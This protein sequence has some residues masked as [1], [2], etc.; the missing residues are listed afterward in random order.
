MKV[1]IFNESLAPLGGVE[2][3]T[4]YVAQ[5]LA[6]RG[7]EVTVI[8]LHDGELHADFSAVCRNVVQVPTF[9]ISRARG[10]RQLFQVLPTVRT[11]ARCRSDVICV[12][13]SGEI[14]CA[15]LAGRVA[16]APVVCYFHGFRPGGCG[17]RK[18][19]YVSK[20]ITVSKFIR[21]QWV[22]GG[23]EADWIEVVH[24]GVDQADY[25]I[26]GLD[27][28]RTA[29]R[30]L[31]LPEDGFLALYYG[32][33]DPLKGIGVLLDAWRLLG[34]DPTMNRLLV[35]GSPSGDAEGEAYGEEIRAGAPP[36]CHWLPSRQDV[37][38]PLH[39]ADVVVVPSIVEEAFSR[40]VIEGM[41]TG[42]PVVAA[43]IGGIPEILEERF[44]RLLFEAGDAVA[45]AEVVRSVMHWR[46]NEPE[47]ADA[48]SAHI[49]QHFT[50]Q[51]MIDGIERVFTGAA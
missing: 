31:G 10:L 8:Y 49:R 25:P 47:L 41:S 17:R 9:R 18:G 12:Q 6:G 35:V 45:L 7:H 3:Q 40:S 1:L 37:T 39:A 14:A 34:L 15:L 27:E 46:E 22:S 50:G 21:D 5:Q 23:L 16:R 24:N 44:S 36:G 33:L 20:F 13:R 28:R 19:S 30:Q 26:G 38:G 51:A 11:I 42:R 2:V 29:R 4:L 32:R 43:R 48:C